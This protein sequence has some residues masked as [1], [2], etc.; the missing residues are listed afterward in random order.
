MKHV[1][2]RALHEGLLCGIRGSRSRRICLL[3][4][5]MMTRTMTRTVLVYKGQLH[6]LRLIQRSHTL[7]YFNKVYASG[8]VDVG[9][10][11]PGV[12]IRP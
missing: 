11:I 4:Y 6:S 2:W 10:M 7:I 1:A 5:S 12:R 8:R 3:E 9:V